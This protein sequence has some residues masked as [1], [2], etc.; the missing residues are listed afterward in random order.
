MILP[1]SDVSTRALQAALKG[2]DERQRVIADNV[3][4]VETPGFHAGVVNF[5]DSLRAALTE[6]GD[7][8]NATTTVTSSQAPT[9]LNG[10]NVNL[11][12]EMVLQSES[13]LR[14]QLVVAA[15]NSKYSML[16]TA[17]SGQ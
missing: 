14:T 9:R 12:M 17:I 16:R 7:V 15:L 6:G 10:N 5:E 1:I 2:L 8:S 11:D 13:L 3:A 4:N